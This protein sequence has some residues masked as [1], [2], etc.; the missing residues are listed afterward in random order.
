MNNASLITLSENSV[1]NNSKNYG[2]TE[3]FTNPEFGS[4]RTAEINGKI[5]F[6]GSDVA[7]ALGYSNPRDAILKHCRYVAK[8]DTPHPQSKGKTIEMSFIPEGDVYRLIVSSKLPTA[9]K[10][11]SWVFDEVLPSIRHTGSYS[12]VPNK[13]L[14]N[15]VLIAHSKNAEILRQIAAEY[16][17]K[18]ENYKQILDAYAT[19][20]IAGDFLLPLPK[21]ERKTYSATEIGEMMGLSGKKI[22]SITNQYNLKTSEYGIWVHDKSKY[23]SKE[24]DTFR[25]FDSVIPA[26][27]KELLNVTSE[28]IESVAGNWMV[29]NGF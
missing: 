9:Q 27:K 15:Q 12:A 17:G 21:M 20:E 3:V 14:E 19:K 22:G 7:K 6:C 29:S 13:D 11:E 5:H 4:V 24:V 8:C 26:I 16:Q 25:Y 1:I 10:F 23:S 28:K 2:K 18:S